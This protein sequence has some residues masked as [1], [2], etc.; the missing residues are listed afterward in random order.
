MMPNSSFL[1]TAKNCCVA[2]LTI[3][4]HSCSNKQL[5]RKGSKKLRTQTRPRNA[6]RHVTW[7]LSPKSTQNI[8]KGLIIA[9]HAGYS[10]LINSLLESRHTSFTNDPFLS[11][12]AGQIMQ[13]RKKIKIPYP[14]TFPLQFSASRLL[15]NTKSR[16]RYQLKFPLPAP[17]FSSHPE[18]RHEN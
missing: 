16:S 14:A 5:N 12:W 13:S 15:N 3:A 17:V 6:T 4:D 9:W 2:R 11:A 1:A 10:S 8:T 18:H 7:Y